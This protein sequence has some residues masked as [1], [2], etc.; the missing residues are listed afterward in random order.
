MSEGRHLVLILTAHDLAQQPRAEARLHQTLASHFETLSE[1]AVVLTRGAPGPDT[2][3]CEAAESYGLRWVVYLQ[4]GRRLDSTDDG[5]TE[6]RWS[7]RTVD[8]PT[9]SKALF[10]AASKAKQA[11]W[12]V[13]VVGVTTA[14][15]GLGEMGRLLTEAKAAGYLAGRLDLEE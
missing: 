5:A 1:D 4:D 11:G 6:R 13:Q 14:E 15:Q 7:P 2:W 10:D 8:A 12:Q 9:Q 3:V